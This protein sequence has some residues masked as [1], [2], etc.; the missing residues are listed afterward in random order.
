MKK[1]KE[2]LDF[3]T[4]KA[5]GDLLREFCCCRNGCR[6]ITTERSRQGPFLRATDC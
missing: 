6:M 3:V 1:H 5:D 4:S 2:K